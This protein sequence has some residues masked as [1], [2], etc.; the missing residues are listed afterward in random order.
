MQAHLKR[1]RTNEAG[2]NYI[3]QKLLDIYCNGAETRHTIYQRFWNDEKIYGLGDT[4]ID[5]YLQ[6][7]IDRQLI[8]L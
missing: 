1:L 4:E 6:P 8:K 3:E 2:L 7:L 5:L